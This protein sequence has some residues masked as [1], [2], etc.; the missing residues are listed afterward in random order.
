MCEC[1]YC[2]RNA[3][4]VCVCLENVRGDIKYA[5]SQDTLAFMTTTD[6]YTEEQMCVSISS[7]SQ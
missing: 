1:V 2:W 6:G 4:A 5:C 3:F 7:A